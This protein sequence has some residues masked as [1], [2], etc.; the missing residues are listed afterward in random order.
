[1]K[2]TSRK[3]V[4]WFNQTCIVKEKKRDAPEDPAIAS[5]KK[6]ETEELWKQLNSSE[7]AKKKKLDEAPAKEKEKEEDKSKEKSAAPKLEE[8][9]AVPPVVAVESDAKKKEEEEATKLAMEAL[10]AV[11]AMKSTR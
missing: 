1:M 3:K 6:Q 8:N 2:I 7:P 10:A 4:P 5:R 11:K 9:K